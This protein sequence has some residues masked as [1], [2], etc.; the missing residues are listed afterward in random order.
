MRYHLV[1][2]LGLG[3]WGLLDEVVDRYCVFAPVL[4]GDG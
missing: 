4:R 1:T 3:R 2:W